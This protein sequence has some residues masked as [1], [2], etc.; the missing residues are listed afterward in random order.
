M[1]GWELVKVHKTPIGEKMATFRNV[2]SGET[3]E[4]PFFSGCINPP[5]KGFQELVDAGLTD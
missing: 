2:D 4:K 3:L 1:L 5:S